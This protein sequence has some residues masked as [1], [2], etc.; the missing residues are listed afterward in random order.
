MGWGNGN[1]VKFKG[2]SYGKL[3]RKYMEA[4]ELFQDPLFPA[5]EN[6]LGLGR[7]LP[8]R[9]VWKRPT[10]SLVHTLLYCKFAGL[11]KHFMYHIFTHDWLGLG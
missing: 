6:S 7:Q 3:H 2:Q 1:V 5:N 4:N 11:S 10:V 8:S 9:V